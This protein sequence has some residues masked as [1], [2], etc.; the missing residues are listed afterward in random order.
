MGT[1][2]RGPSQH[3]SVHMSAILVQSTHTH[4]HTHGTTCCVSHM[5]K[6]TE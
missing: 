1:L 4:T 5:P 2:R 3:T 6:H